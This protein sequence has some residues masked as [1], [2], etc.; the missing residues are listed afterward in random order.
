MM[1]MNDGL[2][3]VNFDIQTDA[4]EIV[5]ISGTSA[6]SVEGEDEIYIPNF[7]KSNT[8]EEIKREYDVLLRDTRTIVIFGTPPSLKCS[9]VE[10]IV[11]DNHSVYQAPQPIVA[12]DSNPTITIA[13]LPQQQPR[14]S[15]L[16][17]KEIEKTMVCSQYEVS[18]HAIV[19]EH[20]ARNI[21][22]C[23]A[24][25]LKYFP[26]LKDEFPGRRMKE[27][28][29]WNYDYDMQNEYER[30]VERWRKSK[31]DTVHRKLSEF[32]PETL[33]NTSYSKI[34]DYSLLCPA[35]IRQFQNEDN[36]VIPLDIKMLID[37][38]FTLD[39][40][41]MNLYRIR[42][43]N[44]DIFNFGTTPFHTESIALWTQMTWDQS[45]DGFIFMV[46]LMW[47][48]EYIMDEDGQRRNKLEYA[49]SQWH[50]IGKSQF[51]IMIL[52]NLESFIRKTKVILPSVCPLFSGIDN[53][54]T[55]NWTKLCLERIRDRELDIYDRAMSAWYAG[56]VVELG[57]EDNG[58][59][60]EVKVHYTGYAPQYDEW[61]PVDSEFLAP[62]HLYSKEKDF[63]GKD[64]QNCQEWFKAIVSTQGIGKVTWDTYLIG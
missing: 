27:W 56:V 63:E 57:S 59:K 32:T 39:K 26:L 8:I 33:E 38:Y 36:L 13:P 62:I 49:V 18:H 17:F 58:H 52:V 22:H 53:V 11:E 64:H 4:H 19:T 61:L 54:E 6:E 43:P 30:D 3:E 51:G 46:D 45:I 34:R 60:G 12:L 1:M 24:S 48:S 15:V 55:I 37:A 47:Y 2:F 44:G 35:F 14:R 21:S 7:P 20:T 23:A 42:E 41:L 28:S 29:R 25:N 31:Y 10:R 16:S 9:I 5:P 40:P 50:K